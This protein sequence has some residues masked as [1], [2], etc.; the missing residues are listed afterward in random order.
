MKDKTVRVDGM[1]FTQSG[2]VYYYNSANRIYLHRY[3]WEKEHGSIP[4]GFEVHHIDGNAENNELDNL[5]LMTVQE[6]REHHAK[7]LSQER[8]DFMRKNLNEKAR[9]AAVAWH[10]S[11]D[12]RAWHKE[13]YEGMKHLLHK[14]GEFT[15]E[16]CGVSF[17]AVDSKSNRFCSNACKSK[18]RRDNGLDD[19]TRKCPVCDKE[20]QCNKYSKK[21]CCSKSCGNRKRGLDRRLSKDSPNLRE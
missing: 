7:E 10:K 6:H 4:N 13:H 17:I 12:G 18:W 5:T 19:V 8:R 16:C 14:K 21:V 2:R 11:D 20:F 3:V 15:C 1:A 9:P